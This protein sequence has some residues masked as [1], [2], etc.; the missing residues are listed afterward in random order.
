[1]LSGTGPAERR[2]CSSD[3]EQRHHRRRPPVT[4]TADPG[5]EAPHQL[6][7]E[8]GYAASNVTSNMDTFDDLLRANSEYQET[9]DLGGIEPK[10]AKGLAVVT[11]IDSR[12]APLPMLGLEPGDAKIMRN[13]GGRVTQDV[14]R[15]LTLAVHLLGVNR[16][17][18]I[19]HTNCKM[20]SATDEQIRADLAT[21]TGRDTGTF[22]PLALPDP[23]LGLDE[24]L[25]RIRSYEF[26]PSDLECAGFVYDVHTG[27]LRL[28]ES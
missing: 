22:E 8:P 4:P 28:I 21:R 14:L 6:T 3:D 20:A 10:A 12:I 15:S 24:D 27:V 1:M 26:L 16:V 11:C 19:H 25:S 18:V 23:A 5:S 2:Q 9:F 13:A 17:A 7:A